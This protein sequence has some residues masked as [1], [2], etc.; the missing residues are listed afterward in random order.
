MNV[1][2]R[3]VRYPREAADGKGERKD[4]SF[5]DFVLGGDRHLF[6][7]FDAGRAANLQLHGSQAAYHGILEG[8]HIGGAPD[9]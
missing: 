7:P 9:Q 2:H 3:L 5:G 1:G 6:P 4:L 8:I